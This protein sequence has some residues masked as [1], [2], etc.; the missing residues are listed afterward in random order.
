VDE[1][2]VSSTKVGIEGGEWK[3][4]AKKTKRA[5]AKRAAAKSKKTTRKSTKR[6]SPRTSARGFK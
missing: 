1:E 5:P 2:A 4:A 6:L 3:M